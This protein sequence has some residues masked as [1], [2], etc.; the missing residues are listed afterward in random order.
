MRFENSFSVRAPI[1][2]VYA[3]LLDLERVAPAMPGA[4]VT[5]KVSDDA[6]KVA[7]KVKLGPMTMNYRGDVTVSEKDPAAHRAKVHV[8]AREARGQGNAT[9]DVTMQLA[10]Q[11]GGTGATMSADVQLAGRA[12]A[13]GRGIIEEVSSKLVDRFAENLASMLGEHEATAEPEATAAAPAG[14]AGAEAPAEPTPPLQDE[15][16]DAGA[17]AAGMV[18]DRMRDPRVLAAAIGG[19]LFLGYLLGRRG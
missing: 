17:L 7:I 5:E 12:A 16:L 14:G 18:A 1:D 15:S 13:M 10:E 19:A 8:K 6:Y 4:E 9:A 11:D 3:A 2:E